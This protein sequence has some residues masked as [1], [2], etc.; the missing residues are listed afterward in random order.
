MPTPQSRAA[1]MADLLEAS[2]MAL[3][4]AAAANAPVDLA[5]MEWEIGRLCAACLD[6][7]AEEGLRLR[8]RLVR[9]MAA[10]E[11]LEQAMGG[12]R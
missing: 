3:R 2:L 6:L 8:P 7:P 4:E 11:E 10:L 9:M 12:H 1:S 5:G